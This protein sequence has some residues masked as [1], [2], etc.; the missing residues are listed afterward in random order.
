MYVGRPVKK[1]GEAGRGRRGGGRTSADW[2]GTY[3]DAERTDWERGVREM[4]CIPRI[5]LDAMAED[6]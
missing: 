2:R 3:V 1:A 6:V 4:L 5:E